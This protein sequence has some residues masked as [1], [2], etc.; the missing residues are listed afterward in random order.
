MIA[1]ECWFLKIYQWFS[2]WKISEG[3]YPMQ[4][5]AINLFLIWTGRIQTVT[6]TLTKTNLAHPHT[7]T[8]WLHVCY[9]SFTDKSRH[10]FKPRLLQILF[11]LLNSYDMLKTIYC[12][13]L[14]FGIVT[15]QF[16]IGYITRFPIEYSGVLHFFVYIKIYCEV[17]NIE[18][19]NSWVIIYQM[20]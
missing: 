8:C 16:R 14:M 13:T 20:N 3:N 9:Y 7:R 15:S 4:S 10:L 11:V 19:A 5:N 12:S 2:G 17:L 1:F 18:S 6:E